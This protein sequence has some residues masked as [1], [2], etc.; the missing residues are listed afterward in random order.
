M[1]GKKVNIMEIPSRM[2]Y[3]NVVGMG[4]LTKERKKGNPAVTVRQCF[5]LCGEAGRG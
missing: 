1:C 2:D 3:L 5:K 4:G